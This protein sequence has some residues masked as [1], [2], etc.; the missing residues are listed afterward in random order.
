MVTMKH[1]FKAEYDRITNV[2]AKYYNID[3]KSLFTEK[4]DGIKPHV[5]SMI[6]Y[7]AY[8]QIKGSTTISIGQ[9]LNRSHCSVIHM[10]KVIKTELSL[11]KDTVDD[12]DRIMKILYG[13]FEPKAKYYE[14]TNLYYC[15]P[16][17]PFGIMQ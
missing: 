6:A 5:R 2:V 1:P 10:L 12:Y 8:N 15:F 9:Y 4:R 14:K 11:Y 13:T 3:R 7:V 17:R 16:C